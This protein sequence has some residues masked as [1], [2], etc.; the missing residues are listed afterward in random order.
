MPSGE[1][2]RLNVVV[3]LDS[4][5]FQNGIS[6]LNRQMKVVQSEFQAATAKLGDFG[7]SADKLKLQ[8]DALSKQIDIQKQKVAALEA[9]YKQSAETKGAD[10]KATQ[11]LAIK[12]NK[13]QA[14]LAGLE[15]KLQKT[16]AQLEKQ[17][18]KWHQLGEKAKEA[19][20]KF[21]S[22]GD[23]VT[24][25]GQNL[26][27]YVSAPLTGL[28]AVAI[29]SAA[30]F[31][32]GLSNIKA[33]SGATGEQMKQLHQLALK[34]GADTK[35]SAGE[36]AKG[37]EELIKAGVSVEDILKGGLKGALDLAAA[38]E[39]EL[40]EAAEIASTALN[41]FRRDNLSVADAANI[42]AGAAN[43]SATDVRELKMGLSQVAAVASSVGLSF[44]DTA[45]ALAVFAQNGLKGSDAGTS[46]KTMLMNLQPQTKAQ[47]ELFKQLNLVTEEGKSIFFDAAGRLKSIDEIAGILKSSMAG[48]TEA[49]RLQAMQTIFGS[50]AIR[51]ANIL[52]KEGADGVQKM[53]QAMGQVTAEQVAA[54]KMNNFNGSLEQLKGSLETAAI[55]FGTLIIPR[56]KEFVDNITEW[57]NKL[58]E[59]SPWQQKLIVGIGL[60]AAAL[61]PVILIIGGLI[62]AV[63]NIVSAIGALLPLLGSAGGALS[64]LAGPVGIAIAVIA[65]LAALAYVVKKNWEPLSEF[66]SSL[67]NGFK[68]AVVTAGNNII[69]FLKQWGPL[70]LAA[71]T[72]PVGL[73]A[74]TV[75]KHWDAIK[76]N[77]VKVFTITKN[78]IMSIW[79][80]VSTWLSGAWNNLSAVAIDA[81]DKIKTGITNAFMGAKDIVTGVWQ[82]I[83]GATRNA[84]NWVI[85]SINKFIRVVNSMRIK[86]PAV[87]IPG[88]GKVG[89]FTI[90]FPHIPEIPKL[91][92]G[93]NY[94]PKDMIAF[95]H[96]GEAVIPK[97]YN[98][99]AGG[100]AGVTIN[101]QSMVVRS[102]QD[103]YKISRELNSL[104]QSAQRARGVR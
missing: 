51:A 101:I 74:Y 69:D 56:L 21:K 34:M 26:T 95:L 49:Q 17:A 45:T 13:A 58:M 16:T 38:G 36:A 14:E 66:F 77:S 18:N 41:A 23:R 80:S 64:A 63:G 89:G 93:T 99:V 33:V 29:K 47:W 100:A 3:N 83:S 9:A 91:A 24:T 85:E 6:Q 11:D 48:L 22:I 72:G 71:L 70:M 102:E 1:I 60:F 8:A 5:G 65:A 35:F 73:A 96:E 31:E 104:I 55:V 76:E 15:N 92:T 81:F 82:S 53:K 10:A 32:Q 43:A 30:D 52:F 37:I 7:S 12:L 19:G 62:G 25:V 42:L 39:L 87:E 44:Q 68:N 98:P 88:V 4:T 97:K 27:T 84:I 2:G 86:V 61:G 50:D 28:G 94:V 54:E 79:N 59:L 46:L 90:G 78:T 103:I 67:W 57:I 40:G 75:V 20:D